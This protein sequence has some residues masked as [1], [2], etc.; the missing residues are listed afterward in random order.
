[1]NCAELRDHFDAYVAGTLSDAESAAFES[2]LDG[3][4]ACHEALANHDRPLGA[5]A[6]L[7]RS[8]SPP[9]D[10]WPGIEQE[11]AS[12]RR[13]RGRV[14]LPRWLLGSADPWLQ[15]AGCRPGV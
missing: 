13:L 11:L 2:H 5:T 7:P 3:C 12:R 1:M 8:V 15:M 9:A 6:K 10:L 4:V 14:T